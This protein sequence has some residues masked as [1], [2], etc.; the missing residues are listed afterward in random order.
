MPRWARFLSCTITGLLMSLVGIVLTAYAQERI[1]RFWSSLQEYL[2]TPEFWSLV[3]LFALLSAVGLVM[4]RVVC[5]L[6]GLPASFAGFLTGGAVAFCYVAF[7]LAGHL[8]EWGG[9][10]AAW[11]R[12][13]PAAGYLALPFA[14]GGGAAN[15]LWERLG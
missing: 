12:I 5:N 1:P 2:V 15:W 3:W 13:W 14:V 7:L 11:P 10:A 4:S 8:P 9:W 6:S